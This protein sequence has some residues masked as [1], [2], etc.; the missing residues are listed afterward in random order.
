MRHEG[1]SAR[2][3][4]GSVG[5]IGRHLVAERIYYRPA[6]DASPG[7]MAQMAAGVKVVT[8]NPARA[9]QG[10]APLRR[11]FADLIPSKRAGSDG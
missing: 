10:Q 7:A 4:N 2:P 6:Q 9:P 5:Y 3:S 8:L 1:K 11:K